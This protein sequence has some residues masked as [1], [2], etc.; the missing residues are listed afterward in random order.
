MIQL[1]KYNFFLNF[2]FFFLFLKEMLKDVLN[3]FKNLFIKEK[4]FIL[5]LF[6]ENFNFI[7]KK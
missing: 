1:I 4:F 7:K 5:T 2:F 6:I 3:Y